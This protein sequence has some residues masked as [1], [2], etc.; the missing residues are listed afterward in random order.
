MICAIGWGLLAIAVRSP[1]IQNASD[2]LMAKHKISA[3][4]VDVGQH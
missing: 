4:F 3:F 2:I 1:P